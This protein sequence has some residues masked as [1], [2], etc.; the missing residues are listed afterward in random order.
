MD[1]EIRSMREQ[2]SNEQKTLKTERDEAERKL[3]AERAK[4]CYLKKKER[5]KVD[6]YMLMRDSL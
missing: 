3:V 2:F 5:R 4:V 6:V 1:R